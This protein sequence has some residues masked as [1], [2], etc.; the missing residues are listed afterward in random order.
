MLFLTFSLWSLL[1]QWSVTGFDYSKNLIFFDP[2]FS[3]ITE[4]CVAW[5]RIAMAITTASTR[6]FV[7]LLKIN[8]MDS[9]GNRSRANMDRDRMIN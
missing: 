5:T 7:S 2:T 9:K 1:W 4:L 6:G 8:K 3:V